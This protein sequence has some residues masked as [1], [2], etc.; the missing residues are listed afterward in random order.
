MPSGVCDSPAA[1]RLSA[2]TGE[3]RGPSRL[4]LH[5]PRE[6][7]FDITFPLTP[8]LSLGERVN[9]FALLVCTSPRTDVQP[10]RRMLLPPHEPPA[11]GARAVPARSRRETLRQKTC[12]RLAPLTC[13]EP[14]RLALHQP[15]YFRPVHGYKA[16]NSFSAKSLPEGPHNAKRSSRMGKLTRGRLGKPLGWGEG[17][18]SAR[19]LL[20]SGAN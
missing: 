16:R 15:A 20:L 10:S 8:S 19:N 14:G 13:C 4:Q 2:L 12:P 9:H 11:I 5:E 7:L 18:G 6:W 1:W 17:E 3:P